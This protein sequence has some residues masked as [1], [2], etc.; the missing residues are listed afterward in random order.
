MN[1][2]FLNDMAATL[3]MGI[4]Y[5]IGITVVVILYFARFV[6]FTHGDGE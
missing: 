4:D 3:D 1:I 2:R 5:V 6:G